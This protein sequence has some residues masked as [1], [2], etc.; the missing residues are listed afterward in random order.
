MRTVPQIMWS[1]F[2]LC[3]GLK[4]GKKWKNWGWKSI[5]THLNHIINSLSPILPLIENEPLDVPVEHP[6][7]H[8]ALARQGFG[9]F[10]QL[11]AS[12]VYVPAAAVAVEA[13]EIAALDGRF[14][15]LAVG[16]ADRLGLAEVVLADQRL[17]ALGR[18]LVLFRGR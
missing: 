8:P 17:A 7:D 2:Y 6:G 18:R 14:A 16:F 1:G 11:G 5:Q 12:Q 13:V 3:S 9:A 10:G 15:G 4:I